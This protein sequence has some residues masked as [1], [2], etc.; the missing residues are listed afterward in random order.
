MSL[1]TLGRVLEFL[2]HPALSLNHMEHRQ[3]TETPGETAAP[4]TDPVAYL[5][6][7]GIEAELVAVVE[8][9]VAPAA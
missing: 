7:F 6:I 2:S 1:A 3:I 8:T 9:P 4:F 5:G